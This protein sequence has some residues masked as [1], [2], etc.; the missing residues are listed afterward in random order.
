MKPV[1]D[2]LQSEYAGRIDFEVF[3]DLNSDRAGSVLARGQGVTAVPTMALVAP[4]G[5]E[6]S[7]WVG[8]QPAEEL[9]AEFDESLAP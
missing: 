6:L 5:A 2:G 9:K 8:S 3:A 7:R 1:V 4:G